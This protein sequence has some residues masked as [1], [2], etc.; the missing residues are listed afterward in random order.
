MR[1]CQH[2]RLYGIIQEHL[3]PNALSLALGYNGY[4][5]ITGLSA[6]NISVAEH[7]PRYLLYVTYLNG[8]VLTYEL[9][10]DLNETLEV[11]LL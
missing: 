8:V 1:L 10:M 6:R 11:D 4:R 3:F 9:K 7:L 5:T 2:R